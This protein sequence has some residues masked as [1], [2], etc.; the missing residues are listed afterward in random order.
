MNL[1]CEKGH[2][3]AE[4]VQNLAEAIAWC[5]SRPRPWSPF[6]TFRS[7]DIAPRF[8]SN[9][10]KSWIQSVANQRRRALGAGTISLQRK[11][12]GYEGRL[13]AY[14]PDENLACG[15]AEPETQGFFTVDNVPPWDTWVAYLHEDEQTNYLLAWVPG[16]LTR[17]VEGGVRVI[18]EQCVGWVDERCPQLV[19]SL[20]AQGVELAAFG[21][22]AH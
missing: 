4:L 13:L 7:A 11:F 17:M 19:K 8:G 14:F 5:S 3:V 22:S 15:V 21:S 20:A 18:P 2:S 1:D 9:S 12:Y 10:R 6:A 16:P